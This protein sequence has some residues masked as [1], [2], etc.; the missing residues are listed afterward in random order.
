M[1][2]ASSGLKMAMDKVHDA[3]LHIFPLL[4][5]KSVCRCVWSFHASGTFNETDKFFKI[6]IVT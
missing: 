2:V 3:V 1:V 6:R 4:V 5:V